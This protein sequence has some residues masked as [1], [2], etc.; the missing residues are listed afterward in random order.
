MTAMVGKVGHTLTAV[1]THACTTRVPESSSMI[2][3]L[4]K[5]L[6]RRPELFCTSN[7]VLGTLAIYNFFHTCEEVA[8]AE[9]FAATRLPR[10]A[11]KVAPA[12]V[13]ATST[14]IDRLDKK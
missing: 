1:L 3:V 10:L 11:T 12:C 8:L 7:A 4:L 5:I 6:T 2:T 13:A 9:L 14:S